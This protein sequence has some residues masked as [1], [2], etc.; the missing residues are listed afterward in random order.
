[1]CSNVDLGEVVNVTIVKCPKGGITVT[2]QLMVVNPLW[3][4]HKLS[5][6]A[7]KG[8][9]GAIWNDSDLP[10]TSHGMTPDIILPPCA[11]P[12]RQT[13]GLLHAMREGLLLAKNPNA[14]DDATFPWNNRCLDTIMG[15]EAALTHYKK[16]DD[17]LPQ[18]GFHSQGYMNFCCPFTGKRTSRA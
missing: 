12:S 14:L 13:I 4:G 17:L 10:Y 7:Q 8:T 1:M 11:V 15:E 18:M 9:V 6:H 5:L 16:L 3:I 2:V